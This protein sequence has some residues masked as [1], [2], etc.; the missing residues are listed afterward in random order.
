MQINVCNKTAHHIL[1]NRVDLIL[2]KFPEG[3]KN[4]RGIFSTII[5]GFVGWAFEGISSF[6]H[7][8]RHKALH[9][10]V[11]TMSSE[12][13]I[14]Q[15]KLIHLENTLVMYGVYNTQTLE[16]LIKIV[17]TLHSRQSMYERLFTGEITK[18][19]E[20]YSQ[21]H[22]DHG[23]QHFAINSMLY[24]RT[25]KDKYIEL[26]NEFI[27]QLHNKAKAVRILAKGYLTILL[28]T[29]LKLKEILASV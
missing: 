19:Y 27:S 13:E 5:S 3:R 26:Y 6:L 16:K 15:N 21:I 28:V 2:P 10:A 24:L 17:H 22:G 4:K 12:V 20:Y 25:I 14:Q 7:I 1:K 9:K 23:I 11:C 29:P 8:R 18:A